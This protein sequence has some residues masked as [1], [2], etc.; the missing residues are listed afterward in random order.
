MNKA[1]LIAELRSLDTGG[2]PFSSDL[3]VAA[4]ADSAAKAIWRRV[5]GP[6]ADLP[7]MDAMARPKYEVPGQGGPDRM[8]DDDD[9]E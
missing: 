8:R 5:N 7:D 2:S 3:E 6:P 1:D 9:G 4:A